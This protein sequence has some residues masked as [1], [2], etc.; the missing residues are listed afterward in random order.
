MRG[1]DAEGGTDKVEISLDSMGVSI[2]GE[3]CEDVS[4]GGKGSAM[5]CQSM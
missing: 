2:F 5:V 1:D 3:F 4:M